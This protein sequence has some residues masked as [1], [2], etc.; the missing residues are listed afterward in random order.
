MVPAQEYAEDVALL[1]GERA[2]VSRSALN[3]LP[4]ALGQVILAV[5]A[6]PGGRFAARGVSRRPVPARGGGAHFP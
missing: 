6:M 4:V 5:P 3:P 1:V 2:E